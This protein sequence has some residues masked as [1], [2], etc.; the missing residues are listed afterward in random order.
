MTLEGSCSRNFWGISDCWSKMKSWIY[1]CVSWSGYIQQECSEKSWVPKNPELKVLEC[2]NT[3]PPAEFWDNFP[4]RLSPL[5]SPI[6]SEVI[7]DRLYANSSRL[8]P[9]QFIRG[10]K[11]VANVEKGG[12]PARNRSFRPSL[13]EIRPVQ[14]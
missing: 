8:T 3:N 9:A 1:N 7:K 14:K 6:R 12:Q 4:K 10:M 11:A 5:P 2:Y 13:S